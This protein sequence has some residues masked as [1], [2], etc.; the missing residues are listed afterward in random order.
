MWFGAMRPRFDS[1]YPDQVREEVKMD[2]YEY[3]LL[4]MS[5]EEIERIA[6]GDDPECVNL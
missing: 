4:N 3:E 1:W 2:D 5:Q 6:N